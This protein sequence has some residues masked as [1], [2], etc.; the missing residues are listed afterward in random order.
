MNNTG[1]YLAL[2]AA[3]AILPIVP[4]SLAYVLADLAGLI[5][6]LAVRRAQHAIRSARDRSQ[7]GFT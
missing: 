5:S 2:R 3:R 1:L 4:L 7:D 6:Y